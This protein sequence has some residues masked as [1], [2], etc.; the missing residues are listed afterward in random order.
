[1]HHTKSGAIHVFQVALHRIANPRAE[2]SPSLSPLPSRTMKCMDGQVCA[3]IG[4]PYTYTTGQTALT[5][6]NRTKPTIKSM[7]G[8][9][10]GGQRR[11]R[12][13]LPAQRHLEGWLGLFLSLKKMAG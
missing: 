6:Q 12:V 4:S 9:V 13:H 3:P 8:W 7:D 10:G 11:Q 2:R 5:S 1:M